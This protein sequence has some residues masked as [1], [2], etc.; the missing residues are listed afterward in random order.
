MNG[1]GGAIFSF[2]FD[3]CFFAIRGFFNNWLVE[4][5]Q[6]ADANVQGLVK[7]DR[8][9]SFQIPFDIGVSSGTNT[10]ADNHGRTT[11]E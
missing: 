9:R 4:I 6:D 1:L 7:F 10:G 3:G 11:R 8:L 5:L 2:G